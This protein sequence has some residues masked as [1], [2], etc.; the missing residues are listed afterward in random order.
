MRDGEKMWTCNDHR[1]PSVKHLITKFRLLLATL[2]LATIIYLA[3]CNMA[4]QARNTML[5]DPVLGKTFVNSGPFFASE[6]GRLYIGVGIVFI[7]LWG[8]VFCLQFCK[9]SNKS[10]TA[11]SKTSHLKLAILLVLFT[12]FTGLVFQVKPVAAYTSLHR[13]IDILCAGDEEFRANPQNKIDVERNIR[14]ANWYRN[15]WTTQ[16]FDI[17]L[18]IRF[19]VAGWT[20]W[21][22]ADHDNNPM[23]MAWHAEQ[24]VGFETGME[25]NGQT[26]EMLLVLT[27]Q[28]IFEMDGCT[29]PDSNITLMETEPAKHIGVLRHEFAHQFW[30]PHCANWCVM[31]PNIIY[32]PEC[33]QWGW[34]SGC[35]EW[36]QGYGDKWP[37]L[38]RVGGN[39][40]G[41]WRIMPL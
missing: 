22:S 32:L 29:F 35:K 19:Y 36:I 10:K 13:R 4:I 18:G 20:S 30:T 34:C 1:P 31:N 27:G 25:Y 14:N 17:T 9:T 15:Y 11:S 40:G 3:L 26:V 8:I 37:D 23:N 7:G 41:H 16:A 24:Q 2:S 12:L 21:T 28:D 39:P 38:I 5:N 6:I 33:R